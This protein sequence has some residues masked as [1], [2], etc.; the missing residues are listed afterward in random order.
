MA[1]LPPPNPISQKEFNKRWD[2]GARTMR[3][4]DP[5]FADWCDDPT[6][7]GKFQ[8]ICLLLSAV[9]VIITSVIMVMKGL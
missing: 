2:A 9:I 4:L 6:G 7:C 5:G 3:E 1:T 8:L